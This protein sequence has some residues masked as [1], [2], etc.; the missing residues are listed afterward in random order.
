[1]S[2]ALDSRPRRLSCSGS[3]SEL[4]VLSCSASIPTTATGICAAQPAPEPS[5]RQNVCSSA[6]GTPPR[7]Q[8]NGEER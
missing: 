2:A 8:R 5:R 6:P 3:L 7:Q 1:M 4:T